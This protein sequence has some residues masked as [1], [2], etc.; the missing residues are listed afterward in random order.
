MMSGD[1][2]YE[3]TMFKIIMSHDYNNV[4]IIHFKLTNTMSCNIDIHWL[5][6]STGIYLI[7]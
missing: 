6:L 4:F 2:N 1:Y 5:L 3:L 7:Q